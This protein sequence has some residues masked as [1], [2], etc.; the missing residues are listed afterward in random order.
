MKKIYLIFAL[1]II[2]LALTANPLY[3][4][5]SYL[6]KLSFDKNKNWQIKLNTDPGNI[7]SIFIS[8]ASG[9]SKCKKLTHQT[10]WLQFSGFI[11]TSDSLISKV[12]INPN[13]DSISIISY[14]HYLY[15]YPYLSGPNQL[16]ET[17]IYGNYKNSSIP[18]PLKGQGIKAFWTN[19]QMPFYHSL[20][21]SSGNMQGTIK[22]HIYNRNNVLIT[23]GSISINPYPIYLSGTCLDGHFDMDAIDI[24]SDGTYSCKFY[25]QNYSLNQIEIW[26]NLNRCFY[27]KIGNSKITPLDFSIYPDSSI[28][29]DI[30]LLEDFTGINTMEAKS[31]ELLKI[32]PNPIKGGS[33][34]YEIGTPVKAT[35]CRL[36][37]IDMTG[38]KMKSYDIIENTGEL[39]LPSTITNGTYLIQ[40]QMNGKKLFSDQIIVSKK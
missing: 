21:D 28:D 6:D 26:S 3:M 8:S 12:N 32:F 30:H 18:K 2:G 11:I 1:V 25:S 10:D 39:Q 17:F 14:F 24:G 27:Y 38:R 7:D 31:N 4:P 16:T 36:D 37:L 29:L 40:L 34:Q 5:I 9:K 22:G 13:G 15:P 23:S 20:C 33:F 19:G 35:H